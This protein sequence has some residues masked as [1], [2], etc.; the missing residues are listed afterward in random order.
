MVGFA[1]LIN[2]CLGSVYSYSVFRIPLEQALGADPATTGYPY[3]VF[4]CVFA[5]T[6]PMAGFVLE[7]LGPRITCI[8]GAALLGSGW[9]LAG[10]AANILAV[11]LSY[12]L[13]GGM[14][15]G[16]SYGV[17]L[18]VA[19]RWFPRHPGLFAGITLL[20]FGMSPF[21]TAPI[22]SWLISS[23][24]V[25][26]SFRIMGIGFG[27]VIAVCALPL[28]LPS[29]NPH[30]IHRADGI[31]TRQMLSS[32]RFWGLWICF[33]LGTLVGL[34]M[35]GI[36]SPVAQTLV[37]LPAAA[38]AAAVSMMAIANGIGRPIF[39]MLTDHLGIRKAAQIAFTVIIAA[40]SGMLLQWVIPANALIL[41]RTIFAVSF[42]M[43]WLVLGGWLS[44]AP[45]ATNQLFGSRFYTRNYGF[46]Y[47]A[48]GAGAVIGTLSS[49]LLYD[50]F[51]GY[52]MLFVSILFTGVLGFIISIRVLPTK[53]AKAA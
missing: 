17:P 28:H 14:G 24:G 51:G 45:A 49:G 38:A 40:A 9:V 7:R 5:L 8:I 47:T 29:K 26:Q 36:T 46:V 1:T 37:G 10:S 48:Y 16:L 34:T 22:A 50:F 42:T 25:M 19:A 13:L 43:F 52:Q 33:T 23:H 3:M 6:M 11:S 18:A 4:L 35:I 31:G 39:G 20:G 2:L 15:V 30:A 53:T 12:G 27:I 44:I 21:V 41:R 32:P